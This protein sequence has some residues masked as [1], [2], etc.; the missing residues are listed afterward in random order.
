MT[1]AS[2]EQPTLW[3]NL[4]CTVVV[5]YDRQFSLLQP[6][7]RRRQFLMQSPENVVVVW[8][9]SIEKGLGLWGPFLI[10]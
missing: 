5:C 2:P 1:V 10:K 4:T 8:C 9:H 7:Q 3:E 6:N